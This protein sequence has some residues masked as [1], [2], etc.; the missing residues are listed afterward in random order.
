[1]SDRQGIDTIIEDGPLQRTPISLFV[2]I[3]L[4]ASFLLHFAWEMWQVPFFV[5]MDSSPHA[6]VVWLCTRAALGDVGIALLALVPLL[7]QRHGIY[8]LFELRYSHCLVYVATGLLITVAFEYAATEL[9]SRW[10]YK[11][12]M[13]TLPVVGTGLMPLLQWLVLPPV[14]VL[15]SRYFSLGWQYTRR[16]S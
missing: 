9:L 5:G 11:A 8:H 3:L 16:P 1:M 7:W 12:A 2:A 4:V 14:A 15:F 10:E 6:E 13:P